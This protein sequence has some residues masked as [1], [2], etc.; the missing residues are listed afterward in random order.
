MGEIKN[1]IYKIFFIQDNAFMETGTV[2]FAILSMVFLVF[3]YSKYK[4]YKSNPKVLLLFPVLYLGALIIWLVSYMAII[5][6][7]FFLL[8]LLGFLGFSASVSIENLSKVSMVIAIIIGLWNLIV[9]F[10]LLPRKDMLK[11]PN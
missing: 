2:L 3:Y 8:A 10:V 9:F 11:E 4:P 7:L 5:A 1:F 6:C